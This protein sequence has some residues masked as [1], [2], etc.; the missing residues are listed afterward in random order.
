M[1]GSRMSTFFL[2]FKGQNVERPLAICTFIVG[3]FDGSLR[4][5]LLFNFISWC[6]QFITEISIF[7]NR[8]GGDGTADEETRGSGSSSFYYCWRLACGRIL[9]LHC[10][11]TLGWFGWVVCGCIPKASDFLFFCVIPWYVWL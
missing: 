3:I 11:G 1:R 6:L 5:Q 9:R 10:N 8:G 4:T 2:G 7:M